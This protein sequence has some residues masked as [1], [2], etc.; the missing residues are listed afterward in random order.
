MWGVTPAAWIYIL[1]SV[2]APILT[3]VLPQ[4]P[5]SGFKGLLHL[6]LITYASAEALFSIYFF[7]LVKLAQA[8]PPLPAYSRAFLRQT[9]ARA[10]EDRMKSEDV[11][12]LQAKGDFRPDLT[13]S[14][15]LS[16]SKTATFSELSFLDKRHKLAPDDP[17]AVEWREM[18]RWWF[19][20]TPWEKLGRDNVLEWLG[21]SFY[22]MHLEE[23]QTEWEQEGR[24]TIPSSLEEAEEQLEDA[25]DDGDDCQVNNK[26]AF[27]YH[28]LY[29]LEAR[30]GKQLEEGRRPSRS[31][32]LT[33]DKVNVT[34]RPLIKY[35]VTGFFNIMLERRTRKAGF[36]K[37]VDAGM[38]YLIRMPEDWKAGSEETQ[39]VLFIHGLG[40]GLGETGS[41]HPTLIQAY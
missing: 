40:M 8:R 30:A 4:P 19:L 11:E 12:K 3:D 9:L 2:T 25:E 5:S 6:A 16:L 35:L 27:L 32:R 14:R 26:L 41:G 18:F 10:L 34:S 28:G 20:G 38:E 7:H 23:C 17:R 21:W 36:K 1:W 15:S 22:G 24:P 31:I 33:L 37:V 13:R 39:P 29:L